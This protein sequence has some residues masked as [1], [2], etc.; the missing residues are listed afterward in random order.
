M[1]K[2][3]IVLMF[4]AGI[5]AVIQWAAIAYYLKVFFVDY[6]GKLG[7]NS[8]GDG[9]FA[10]IHA[11][12]VLLLLSGA[13][14]AWVCWRENRT[15]LW[16]AITIAIVIVFAWLTLGYMHATGALVENHEVI[17]QSKGE[18][19][20]LPTTLKV[21]GSANPWLAG[22]PDGTTA[23][24]VDVAPAQSPVLVPALSLAPGSA[25]TFTIT[26]GV[27]YG[28]ARPVAPP[29]GGDSVA[30]HRAGAEHGIPDLTAPHESLVGV[31]LG[32]DQP[33]LSPPP[34]GLDFSTASSRDSTVFRPLLKQPFFIGDGRTSTGATQ[35]IIVPVG[36]TR[37]F[38][39]AMDGTKWNDNIGAF[40]VQITATKAP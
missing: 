12:N 35:F 3:A 29:D 1:K 30:P 8:V 33:S 5:I 10:M 16:L 17:R 32:P 19:P 34:A 24:G 23:D 37:F 15:R 31:F 25:L 9:S 26:G 28:P 4:A 20:A 18:T 27:G 13:F 21:P 11:V 39:G 14:A 6:Q 2:I 22:M 40:S 7:V 38:L 36:A